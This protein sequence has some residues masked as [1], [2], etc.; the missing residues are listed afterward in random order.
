MTMY[1]VRLRVA[2]M[3]LLVAL[4]GVALYIIATAGTATAHHG[5]HT[6]EIHVFGDY[7]FNVEDER[8]LVGF[9]DNVFVGRV[10]EQLGTNG[11][12]HSGDTDLPHTQYSVEVLENVKGNLE[13][14]VTVSQIGGYDPQENAVVLVKNDRLLE[15]GQT[16]LFSTRFDESNGWH[17]ITVNGYGDERIESPQER[18]DLV[19][20]FEKAKQEQIDPTG[21]QADPTQEQLDPTGGGADHTEGQV[22]DATS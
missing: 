9:A 16:V 18:S 8:K 5:V 19:Q 11:Q 22:D 14:S 21:G 12:T 1:A 13:G 20:E 7:A 15:P 3:V 10:V 2:L 6:R 4:G 17:V